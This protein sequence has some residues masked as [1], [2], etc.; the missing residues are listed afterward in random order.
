MNPISIEEANA[1][2]RLE[3]YPGLVEKAVKYINDHIAARKWHHQICEVEGY[4]AIIISPY[5]AY[6][7]EV[8]E[9]V[10]K[11]FRAAGWDCMWRGAYDARGPHECFYVN[12]KHFK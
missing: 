8:I 6:T 1:V 4:H 10:V 5:R 3:E 7:K 11:R 2:S 9:K 12:K